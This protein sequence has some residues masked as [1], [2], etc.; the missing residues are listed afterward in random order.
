M[1][2]GLMVVG[3]HGGD[4]QLLAVARGIEVAIAGPKNRP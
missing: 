3:E 4:Q 1:P 2:I